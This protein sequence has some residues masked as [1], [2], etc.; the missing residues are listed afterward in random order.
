MTNEPR[1]EFKSK[2]EIE[3]TE[4]E[5]KVSELR[6]ELLQVAEVQPTV[7][8][9]SLDHAKE[10]V[11]LNT[12]LTLNDRYLARR[13]ELRAALRR[14]ATGHFGICGECGNEI[15]P[16]RLAVSPSAAFCIDCQRGETLW[17]PD[18][19]EKPKL[20][21]SDQEMTKIWSWAA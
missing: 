12:R 2:M 15:N 17:S 4:I 14:I 3:L 16:K 19:K 1:T 20:W 10:L 7:L 21:I 13:D 8:R 11:D 6:G 5:Q 18:T 9:D